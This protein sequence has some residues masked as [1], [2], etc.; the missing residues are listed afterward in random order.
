MAQLGPLLRGPL[1][2]NPGVGW[3]HSPAEDQLGKNPLP[4][5]LELLARFISLQ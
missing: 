4:N 3:P 1:G 2:C 5:S